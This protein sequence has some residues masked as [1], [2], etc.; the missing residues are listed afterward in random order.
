MQPL[1]NGASGVYLSASAGD[2]EVSQ[3]FIGFNHHFGIGVATD[4]RNVSIRGNSLQGNLQQGIDWGLDGTVAT[5]PVPLPEITSARY[6]NGRTIIE[7]TFAA[8]GSWASLIT[9]YANDAPDPS[10]YGEGQYVLGE[11]SA[12]F[13]YG[14]PRR[15]TMVW[16]GDLRG[17]WVTATA[18][19]FV[20]NGFLRNAGPSIDAANGGVMTTTSEFSRVYEVK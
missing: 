13:P 16:P 6:E 18:T 4:A 17:K 10:G 1:G 19:R 20:Y 14:D 15:F 11:V 8:V 7:G 5:T 12:N 2:S 9:V 3:N